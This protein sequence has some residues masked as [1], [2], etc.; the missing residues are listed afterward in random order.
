MFIVI[1]KGGFMT[2]TS[3]P[4]YP[5][6]KFT[7]TKVVANGETIAKQYQDESGNVVTDISLSQDSIDRKKKLSELLSE[8][9]NS[10]NIFSPELNAQIE[11]KSFT[12]FINI[13]VFAL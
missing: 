5:E 13:S 8:Y 2:S 4:D 11:S 1:K 6:Y 9:E 3:T 7:P 10:V 12:Q